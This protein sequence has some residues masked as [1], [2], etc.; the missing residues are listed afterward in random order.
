VVEHMPCH[1]QVMGSSPAAELAQVDGKTAVVEMCSNTCLVI[2]RLRVLVQ[3]LLI[4]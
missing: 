3:P 1:P 2:L 4:T